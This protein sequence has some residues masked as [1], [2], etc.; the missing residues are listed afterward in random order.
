MK[1]ADGRQLTLRE[2]AGKSFV[3]G[4]QEQPSLQQ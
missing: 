2:A 4:P 1:L 3:A